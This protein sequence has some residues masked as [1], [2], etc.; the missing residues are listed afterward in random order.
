MSLRVPFDDSWQLPE[1]KM[2]KAQC[3]C[4]HQAFATSRPA[5]F[6]RDRQYR[7]H[8][9]PTSMGKRPSKLSPKAVKNSGGI[10][11]FHNNRDVVHSQDIILGAFGSGFCG[12]TTNCQ[13]A[14]I[15]DPPGWDLTTASIYRNHTQKLLLGIIAN[16]Q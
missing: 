9:L 11:V 16:S 3:G 1:R 13:L 7:D 15:A 4:V 10:Y 14:A 5:P 2:E 12:R 8:P 6:D